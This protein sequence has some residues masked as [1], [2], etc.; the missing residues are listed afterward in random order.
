M[1]ESFGPF[2]IKKNEPIVIAEVGVN[3]GGNFKLAKKYIE[4]C[5]KAGADAIKFQ[6][7]KAETLVSKKSP[8]Y[9]DLRFE[10][11]KS[12]YEL[13]KK[14][15]SLDYIHYK[16]LKKF[17]DQK[18]ILFMTTLFSVKDV[19]KYNSLLKVYKISSSDIT[20]VP[21]LKK[22]GKMK[23]HTILSTGAS[24]IKE[25]KF[26]LKILSLPKNKVCLMHCVLNYPTKDKIA[27]L[28][29]IKILQRFFKGYIIGYSDHTLIDQNLTALSLADDFGAQI[30][31]KHFT[32]NK[33]LK[34]NDH[35][36]AMDSNDLIQLKKLINKKNILRGDGKKNI[37]YEKNS[38][39]Y[40]RRG[41]YANRD[42]EKNEAFNEHN[43]IT[44][45][46]AYGLSARYWNQV[47]G[48]KAKIKIKKDK[49]ITRANILKF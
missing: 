15:D 40:A 32:L 4:E 38:I 34:G 7:Y 5:K 11:S 18:K 10:K 39:K 16:K 8:A 42:I 24:T 49:N 2:S 9:W 46:P 41:I 31:E 47:I 35:Y 27:N 28:S 48:K 26:A 36:H 6:T 1:S 3:H 14:Y 17:C 19:A 43:L 21:L 25:I 45:R 23:K 22:I 30:I 37:F 33:K 12:Q 29:Y 20:N 13:F 44:L